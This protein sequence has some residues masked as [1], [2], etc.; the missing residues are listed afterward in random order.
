MTNTVKM[1]KLTK[2]EY[3]SIVSPAIC[4]Y[5]KEMEKAVNLKQKIKGKTPYWSKWGYA[6]IFTE[7]RLNGARSKYWLA[8]H[9]VMPVSDMAE[10]VEKNPTFTAGG[11]TFE[12]RLDSGVSYLSY[13]NSPYVSLYCKRIK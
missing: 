8:K 7:Q 4:K 6:R 2:S 12:V 9:S 3:H 1:N 13:Y 5:R 10:Y 11:M